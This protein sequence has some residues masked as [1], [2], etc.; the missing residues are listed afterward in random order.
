MPIIDAIKFNG[1]A[2]GD[3]LVYNSLFDSLCHTRHCLF[4]CRFILSGCVYYYAWYVNSSVC[5][6]N[7]SSGR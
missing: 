7:K 4:S 1:L 6:V 5:I 3:W 2:N